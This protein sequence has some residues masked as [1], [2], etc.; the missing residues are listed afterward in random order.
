MPKQRLFIGSFV[1]FKISKNIRSE[2]KYYFWTKRSVSW[3][4]LAVSLYFEP[5]QPEDLS[6]ESLAEFSPW[7]RRS[8]KKKFSVVFMTASDAMDF[9]GFTDSVVFLR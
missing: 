1:K 3:L 7:K 4:L 8:N 2:V 5:S 9:L 6:L